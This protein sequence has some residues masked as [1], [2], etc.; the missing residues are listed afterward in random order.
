MCFPSSIRSFFHFATYRDAYL[1]IQIVEI[2]PSWPH[3]AH[4]VSISH[5]MSADCLPASL[6]NVAC[7]LLPA[8]SC[9]SPCPWHR[10]LLCLPV[11]IPVLFNLPPD[12]SLTA[13]GH[14]QNFC[15]IYFFQLYL[16]LSLLY[17][18][19]L[20]LLRSF[21][22]RFIENMRKAKLQKC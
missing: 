16:S 4:F 9:P 15:S 6:P 2:S 18:F 8:A 19:S 13:T 14:E 21:L 17:S 7:C 20:T 5:R 1:L 10:L 12:T 22:C 11:S 3:R